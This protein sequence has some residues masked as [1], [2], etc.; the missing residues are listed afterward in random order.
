MP[1]LMLN[2]GSRMV[3]G[4]AAS[5]S[6]SVA[7]DTCPASARPCSLLHLVLPQQPAALILLRFFGFPFHVPVHVQQSLMF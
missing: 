3:S 6:A 4:H 7:V 1:Q 5:A 2:D